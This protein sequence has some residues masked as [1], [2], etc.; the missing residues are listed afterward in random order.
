MK[1]LET[2][3]KNGDKVAAYIIT[4][5]LSISIHELII[6]SKEINIKIRSPQCL[7][8]IDKA[9]ILFE[10]ILSAQLKLSFSPTEWQSNSTVEDYQNLIEFIHK[11]L[12][13]IDN[14]I[15]KNSDTLNH[16]NKVYHE[17]Q[18]IK[19]EDRNLMEIKIYL[20][21]KF[22]F[23]LEDLRDKLFFMKSQALEYLDKVDSTLS[24]FDDVE[25]SLQKIDFNFTA[26]KI[27]RLYETQL[28]KLDNFS[29][30]DTF[31]MALLK[32]FKLVQKTQEKFTTTDKG[33]LETAL[34]D[35]YLTEHLEAVYQEWEKETDKINRFYIQLIKGYF[36][37]QISQ[38]SL[39]EL[40]NILHTIK[41]NLEDFYLTIRSG[42]IIK[43]KEN[44]KTKLLQEIIVKDRTF[45]IYKNS[46]SR[47]IELLKAEDSKVGYRF[48]NKVLSQLLDFKIEEQSKG[49]EAIYQQMVDLHALNLEIYLNDI[50]IY[51]KELEKKDLEISKL[52]FKME[53]DIQ[54]ERE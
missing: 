8:D 16:S 30:I 24:I 5:K 51:G 2:T 31:F 6:Y 43:Y 41:D 35:A 52:M 18:Q 53:T 14:Q 20:L 45:K 38:H 4:K 22:D 19:T 37:G 49:Y 29:T 32:Q 28:K 39:L 46:Q 1:N 47:F 36:I 34:K 10:H 21:T 27:V 3:T 44:P 11:A 26:T 33:K 12:N 13:A 50:E 25:L 40:F 17:L 23:S 54:K 15:S 9:N 48:L 7:L 42:I